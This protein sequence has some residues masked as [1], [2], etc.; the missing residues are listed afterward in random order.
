MIN[1]GVAG[2]NIEEVGRRTRQLA[3]QLKPQ[4]IVYGYTLNDLEGEGY[5][6][7]AGAWGE[8]FQ[9]RSALVRFFGPRLY[10][11]TELVAPPKG[12]YVHEL[13]QNYEHNPVTRERLRAGLQRISQLGRRRSVCVVVFI[14]TYLFHLNRWH[15]MT[16]FY[17]RVAEQAG[18]L[19]LHPV[20]SLD[21]VVGGR[22]DEL[23]V[24]PVDTHPSAEGHARFAGALEAGIRALPPACI[25]G[26]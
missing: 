22:R 15:P 13:S 19:G 24:S 12:S 26:L 8:L 16:D 17:D 2:F 18:E 14:H 11:L 4:L 3:K 25:A 9:S 20:R 1:A 6:K 10:E 7:S 23:W 5:V 21:A